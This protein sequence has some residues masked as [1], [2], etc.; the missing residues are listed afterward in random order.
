MS[1]SERTPEQSGSPEQRPGATAEQDHDGVQ[2][3][4]RGSWTSRTWTAVVGLAALLILLIV[5]IAQN[6]KEVPIRLFGWSWHPPLAVAILA[7]VAAGLLIAVCAGTLRILQLRRR[8][9]RTKRV[10]K[11]A[12]QD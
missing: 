7:A 1:R 8:V 4:L 5:F 10:Q 3:P 12:S 2:D 9:R 11:Q 6:T